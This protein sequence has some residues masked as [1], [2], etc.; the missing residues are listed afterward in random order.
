MGRGVQCVA[1]FLVV[2][3]VWIVLPG[4]GGGED[5]PPPSQT[6]SPPPGGG[7]AT[8][9]DPLFV[10]QWHLKNTGQKSPNGKGTGTPGEDVNI[11][12]AWNRGFLGQ[13]IRIHV[14]DDGLEQGHE[15]LAANVLPGQGYN[16]WHVDHG[17][18]A[19]ACTPN[20]LGPTDPSPASPSDNHGTSVAGVAAAS[21]NTVGGRGAAPASSLVGYNLLAGIDKDS[22]YATAMSHHAELAHINTN[23]W[24]HE[25]GGLILDAGPEWKSAVEQGVRT[26]RGG[27]GTIYLFAAGNGENPQPLSSDDSNS[28]GWANNRHVM[29]ICA[30]DAKGEKSAYSEKGANLWVCAPSN[31]DRDDA[32]DLPAITTTDRTGAPGYNDGNTR[33]GDY[34]NPNYTNGF[35]GTSSATPLAAGV[36]ALVLQ[37][38]PSLGWRDVRLI[39]AETARKNDPADP[40]WADIGV[41]TTG[42][43]YHHNHKYGFGVVNADAAVQRATNWTNVGAQRLFSTTVKGV[44]V[45]IPEDNAA[46]VTDTLTVSGSGISSIEFI[47]I[48]FKAGHGYS[49]DLNVTLTHAD[50]SVQS[51]LAEQH[52]CDGDFTR[53]DFCGTYNNPA[54]VFGSAR[55][56]GEAADGTWTLRV[57]D[58]APGDVGT[59]HSWQLTFYGR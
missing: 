52:L 2:M 33:P 54:W 43:K 53:E 17:C 37:A 44:E 24:G 26:G 47:E 42:G 49:G 19:P 41:S 12:P 46:G 36:T 23:S 25:D 57:S 5:G 14:V 10:D 50:T 32:I 20:G 51:K 1:S 35:R 29:A 28:S 8:I 38:N 59:F 55:H 3:L 30:V 15:D 58:T 40:G 56:L 21:A 18:V 31:A 16:F 22:D 45:A 7:V 39:L 4:C 27:R 11:E 34:Q 6:S 13:G 48:T 9:N